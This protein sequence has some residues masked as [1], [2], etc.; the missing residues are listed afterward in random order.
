MGGIG[1]LGR[2][3]FYANKIITT[4]EGGMVFTNDHEL[5][6][7][8]RSLRNLCSSSDR[9]FYHTEIGHNYRLTNLQAAVG[10]A[11][12]D[13]IEDH[14]G[15]KRWMAESYRSRLSDLPIA[16]PMERVGQKNVYWMYRLVLS[17]EVPFD[18]VTFAS[19]LRR[20]GVDTRPLFLG[21]HEQPV[22][23]KVGF[24]RES[25]PVTERLAGHGLYLPSGLTLT[26]TQIEF[27]CA[28]VHDVLGKRCLM[29]PV[30]ND[31]GGWLSDTDWAMLQKAVPIVCVDVLPRL[32]QHVAVKAK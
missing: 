20:R 29:E 32:G 21:M 19:T 12:V 4:G 27:V 22:F 9:R 13:R 25:Y 28:A 1:D 16:L 30:I 6:E 26:K 23:Q 18:A 17:D 15:H 7:R 8:F 3:S 2:F 24:Y 14:I 31:G 5:A 10:V 11:Q